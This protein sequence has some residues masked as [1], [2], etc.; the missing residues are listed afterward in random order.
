[1][2][3]RVLSP[4]GDFTFG[5]GQLNYLV[6]VPQAVAQVCQT[7]LRLFLGEW[8]LDTTAGVPYAQGVLG[9]HSQAQAD[10]TLLAAIYNVQGVTSV[11]NFQ[12][13]IDPNT[14]SYSEVTGTLNTIY[15]QTELEI[16]N[17][18]NF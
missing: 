9:K 2:R 18:T 4:T 1:M 5:Q 16:Q 10:A 12:S 15:G 3:T 8:Y 6:D 13:T 11:V 17:E 7:S 14:R